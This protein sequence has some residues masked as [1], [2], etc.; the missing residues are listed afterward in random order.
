MLIQ[1]SMFPIGSGESASGEVSKIIDIIDKSGLP[2]KMSSMSTVIEGDWD[3]IIP[4]INLCRMKLR[5]SNNRV[6]MVMTMD[7]RKGGKS[8]IE[9]KVESI[10][11]KLNRNIKK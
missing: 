6:Y 4:I 2:Y 3:E 10:E 7:D 5:E 8:R 1:F 11:R 9:G